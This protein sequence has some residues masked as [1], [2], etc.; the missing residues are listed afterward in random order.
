MWAYLDLSFP[1][2]K[3]GP[4]EC[5]SWH[6]F[7]TETQEKGQSRAWAEPASELLKSSTRKYFSLDKKALLGARSRPILCAHGSSVTNHWT[8]EVFLKS[9]AQEKQFSDQKIGLSAT[10]QY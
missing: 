6:A 2:L 5:C 10:S 1:L 8:E 7:K 4:L 3:N 9:V